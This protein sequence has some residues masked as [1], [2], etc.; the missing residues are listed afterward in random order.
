MLTIKTIAEMRKTRREMA[1][2]VGF[3]PTMGALHEGH[4][5]LVRRARA[6]NDNVVVS[7]FVNPSQFGPNEDLAKYPRTPDTDLASLQAEGADVVFMPDAGEM[8]P[9]DFDTWVEV[10]KVTERLESA[11]R[12]GHFRGVATVVAVLFN[13][14]RPDRAYFGRK[15]AQQL[16]VVQKMV[17][18]LNM[19][20]EIVPM[21]M[22]RE[23]DGL[24]MSSRNAYLSPDE[25]RAA[26]VLWQALSTCRAMYEDGIRDASTLRQ[27]V[28]RAIAREP[29]AKLDYVSIADAETLDELDSIENREALVSLAVYVGNTRLID[30]VTLGENG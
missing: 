12:P 23:K 28:E 9:D 22:V 29:F 8:Y 10:G 14:V 3:I 1:S 6:E 26:K 7:I 5:S 11:S 2:S 19:G 15:D 20:V 27:A 30:N 4:L 21:P 17:R 18:D 25:R 16:A 24:A 13:I